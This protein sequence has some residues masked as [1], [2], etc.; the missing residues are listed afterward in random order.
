MICNI[1]FQ[2]NL[3]GDVLLFL[4]HFQED[5]DESLRITA[6]TGPLSNQF[7]QSLLAGTNPGPIPPLALVSTP[8]YFRS[9][10]PRYPR[11]T[12]QPLHLPLSPQL[13]QLMP[14]S[15]CL[16]NNLLRNLLGH[17]L[18]NQRRNQR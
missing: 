3:I 10:T 14:Q 15:N 18:G 17:Q 7:V 11:P 4:V 13:H 1:T 8:P 6:I 5:V 12:H 9:M 16:Q 2:S